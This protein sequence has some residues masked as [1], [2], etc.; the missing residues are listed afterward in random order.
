MAGK[1][2]SPLESARIERWTR[3]GPIIILNGFTLIFSRMRG[4]L[5]LHAVNN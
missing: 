3:H 4:N 2:E 5:I 1:K